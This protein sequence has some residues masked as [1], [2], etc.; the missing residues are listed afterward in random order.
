MGVSLSARVTVGPGVSGTTGV[1]VGMGVSIRVKGAEP[2][3][4]PLLVPE[5]FTG[6][7]VSVG[8]GVLVGA[9]AGGLNGTTAA[10]GVAP[11]GGPPGVAVGA[12]VAVG[13][14][15]GGF[16]G[17]GVDAGFDPDGGGAS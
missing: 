16:G 4:F 10:V 2:G 14:R 1:S 6:G 15:G 3:A 17:M 12:L 8:T 5:M 9:V 13:F 11:A 7:G